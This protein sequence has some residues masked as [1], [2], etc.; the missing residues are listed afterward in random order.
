MAIDGTNMMITRGKSMKVVC[1]N[2]RMEYFKCTTY[3][4]KR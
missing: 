3:C 1:R 2:H 4:I